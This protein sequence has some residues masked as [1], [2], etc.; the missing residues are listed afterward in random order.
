V[1][2]HDGVHDPHRH[3][4]HLNDDHRDGQ[5]EH[6]PKLGFPG[7]HPAGNPQGNRHSA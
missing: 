6:G 4:T 7:K 3:H 5:P 1:A 2:D